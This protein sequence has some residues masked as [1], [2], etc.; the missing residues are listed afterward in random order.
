M[1]VAAV[2]APDAATMKS[3]ISTAN[4]FASPTVQTRN[5]GQMDVVT[6][7]ARAVLPTRYAQAPE[8]VNVCRT[9]QT[10]NAATTDAAEIVAA[11]RS[12]KAAPLISV[13]VCPIALVRNAGRMDVEEAVARVNSIRPAATINASVFPTVRVR[14]VVPTVAVEPVLLIIAP[15]ISPALSANAFVSTHV[16]R[17]AIR[18]ARAMT[19]TSVL[20]TAVAV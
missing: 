7:A 1:V 2:V 12:A 8:F 6:R 15:P 10:N 14:S 17:R 16:A 9:A 3:A 18:N 13:S 11:A 4:V 5:A 19:C 20:R